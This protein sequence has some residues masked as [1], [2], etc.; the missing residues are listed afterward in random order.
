MSLIR[1][2]SKAVALFVT[3]PYRQISDDMLLLEPT[4]CVARL[5]KEPSTAGELGRLGLRVRVTQVGKA[6]LAIES[7]IP[8]DLN[9]EY[10]LSL[11]KLGQIYGMIAELIQSPSGS[12][13]YLFKMN[14]MFD[15]VQLRDFY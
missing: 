14:K 2:T 6:C 3:S 5:I 13:C 11:F 7:V 9:A 15:E 1:I 4:G 10:Q 12:Y 8:V